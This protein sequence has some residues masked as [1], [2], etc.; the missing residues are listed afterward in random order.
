MYGGAR[1]PYLEDGPL[2]ACHK[3]LSRDRSTEQAEALLQRT[4]ARACWRGPGSATAV[5]ATA[6]ARHA[7]RVLSDPRT[8]A[9]RRA[10]FRGM[11]AKEYG[12]ERAMTPIRSNVAASCLHLIETITTSAQPSSRLPAGQ[13]GFHRRRGPHSAPWSR[14]TSTSMGCA[15]G[16]VPLR[17]VG[18]QPIYHGPHPQLL[19]PRARDPT[20]N[21]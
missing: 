13:H 12:F 4:P 1:E 3:R 6:A 14:R 21:V 8:E 11:N 10:A 18:T 19:P 7:P 17:V 2:G 5:S 9:R 15:H 20:D 16:L